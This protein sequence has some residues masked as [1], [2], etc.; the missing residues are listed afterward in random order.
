M[1][2]KRLFFP[3]AAI[4]AL[5]FLACSV[6]ASQA[7]VLEIGSATGV[8]L[9]QL[10]VDP[11]LDLEQKTDAEAG[12]R[13]F[14]SET[15]FFVELAYSEKTGI[16]SSVSN[17]EKFFT[18]KIFIPEEFFSKNVL[19]YEDG[20]FRNADSTKLN[21]LRFNEN[22]GK[23][24][25]KS[26][27]LK[28]NLALYRETLTL[29]DATQDDVK[30]IKFVCNGFEKSF[31]DSTYSFDTGF[32]SVSVDFR[33]R[34]VLASSETAGKKKQYFL[35]NKISVE[36]LVDDELDEM[37]QQSRKDPQFVLKKFCE[38]FSN[39]DGPLKV[40]LT[41]PVLNKRIEIT[42]VSILKGELQVNY[43]KNFQSTFAALLQPLKQSELPDAGN[44]ASKNYPFNTPVSDLGDV[45]ELKPADSTGD[46]LASVKL[47]K[48][49]CAAFGPQWLVFEFREV[50]GASFADYDKIKVDL[51]GTACAPAD[52]TQM[53]FTPGKTENK[54]LEREFDGETFEVD[55]AQAGFNLKV[56]G[57]QPQ[58]GEYPFKFEKTYGIPSSGENEVY[59]ITA[60][61]FP[62][63]M[64]YSDETPV[65][66]S[67]AQPI[68]CF[69]TLS[70]FS[71]TGS[72]QDSTTPAPEC[73]VLSIVVKQLEPVADETP[74]EEPAEAAVK[75]VIKECAV[76]GDFYQSNPT[77]QSHPKRTWSW[78]YENEFQG[79]ATLEF[80]FNGEKI[81]K[82]KTVTQQ[83]QE[84]WAG[85]PV[86]KSRKFI[87]KPEDNYYLRAEGQ[88]TFVKCSV[89][90]PNEEY[91]AAVEKYLSAKTP[92][93][94]LQKET[95]RRE[96]FFGENKL[97]T[98]YSDGGALTFG[99]D[100]TN[101]IDS[102]AREDFFDSV[103]SVDLKIEAEG[104]AESASV[105]KTSIILTFSGT[106]FINLDKNSN[107]KF[108][109]F[110]REHKNAVVSAIFNSKK[111]GV[112]VKLEQVQGSIGSDVRAKV[113]AG[114]AKAEAS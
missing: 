113:I 71:K 20:K 1:L 52:F 81:V 72:S 87:V 56:G 58:V 68:A 39:A 18:N 34:L 7:V 38:G 33:N 65:S 85:A 57:Y 41:K 93:Q 103:D 102:H 19:V 74:L 10:T 54:I 67:N 97:E 42:R 59:E 35:V 104:K 70:G 46:W 64:K 5:F 112:Y 14:S 84:H 111:N 62:E 43:K 50:S 9:V 114:L 98:S 76:S 100:F 47:D 4:F 32:L 53:V 89:T 49:N 61:R 105:S 95:A 24:A 96:R 3:S 92:A 66:S 79:D 94:E 11:A 31:S 16:F 45:K 77:E 27:N 108:K 21:V 25:E 90:P 88:E 30:K 8:K 40:V 69:N 22:L 99:I 91:T 37:I 109:E 2:A 82:T 101:E 17:A 55:V 12:Y 73:I 26:K 23:V 60:T 15:P 13:E 6:N 44:F 75:P 29:S 86:Y 83:V 106:A 28:L 51:S 80:S 63:I 48:D 36:G 110:I 107:I 78:T